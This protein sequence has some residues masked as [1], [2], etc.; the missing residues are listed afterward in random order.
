MTLQRAGDALSVC[1]NTVAVLFL[2][3]VDNI[4][5]D[6]A[7]REQLRS[8]VEEEGHVELSDAQAD[9]LART[10]PVHIVLIMAT[11]LGAVAI[12]GATGDFKSAAIFSTF[13]AF[14][15][16]GVARAFD[17]RGETEVHVAKK[18]AQTAAATMLG[19]CGWGALVLA[20]I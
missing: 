17:R 8:R 12:G 14:L 7:L 16:A 11:L 3:E 10:K 15:L 9:A 2:L 5:F 19:M 1:L 6:A 20:S 13:L 18:V 4:T